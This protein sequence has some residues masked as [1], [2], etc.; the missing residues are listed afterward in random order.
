MSEHGLVFRLTDREF[1]NLSGKEKKK[2]KW[3]PY[4]VVSGV[5]RSQASLPS[6]GADLCLVAASSPQIGDTWFV[7]WSIPRVEITQLLVPGLGPPLLKL[8]K[9]YQSRDPNLGESRW[10]PRHRPWRCRC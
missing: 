10:C 9:Q 5:C 3:R 2:E 8:Y 7:L 1:K 4:K 6:P